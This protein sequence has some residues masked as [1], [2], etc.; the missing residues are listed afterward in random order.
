[1]LI[2]SP[3][4]PP[5]H[6]AAALLVVCNSAALRSPTPTRK[7]AAGSWKIGPS[8]N[9]RGAHR[10]LLSITSAVIQHVVLVTTR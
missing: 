10:E 3:M 8:N 5:P 7:A 2:T 1:M 6:A 9:L 4:A